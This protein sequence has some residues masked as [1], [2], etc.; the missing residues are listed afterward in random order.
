MFV[1]NDCIKNDYLHKNIFNATFLIMKKKLLFLMVTALYSVTYVN[2]QKVWDFANVTPIWPTSTAGYTTNTIKDNLGIYPGVTITATPI[3]GI[4]PS[5]LTFTDGFSGLRYFRMGQASVFS[6]NRPTERYLY[7]ATTGAGTI[8]IWFASGGGGGRTIKVTDGT[9][10]IGSASSV[11]STTPS[12][13]EAQYTQTSGN[14]YIYTGT[15]TGVNIYKIEITGTT[16]T[17]QLMSSLGIN[18]FE[19]NS[20]T[21]IYSDGKEVFISNVTSST[22]VDI[23]SI[24]GALIKSLKTETNTSFALDSG[25]YIAKVKTSEGAKSVKIAVK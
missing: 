3:G 24:T 18:D 5:N 8:K 1:H 12:I 15:G 9:T 2:A 23:Y 7:F 4:I 21:N 14:I 11:N 6:N 13:L 19:A 17:T 16:G 20:S 10:E 22:K 25:I